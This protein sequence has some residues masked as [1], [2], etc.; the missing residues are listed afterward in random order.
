MDIDV[1]Y[2]LKIYLKCGKLKY[3]F[4]YFFY[5]LVINAN[6]TEEYVTTY[7]TI[8]SSQNIVSPVTSFGTATWYWIDSTNKYIYIISP[9]TASPW[10]T[11]RR[12]TYTSWVIWSWVTLTLSWFGTFTSQPV[13]YVLQGAKDWNFHLY[14][15]G[16]GWSASFATLTI[17]PV[18]ISGTTATL[19][20]ANTLPVVASYT[21]R[22]IFVKWAVIYV[23]YGLT[24]APYTM[25]VTRKYSAWWSTLTWAALLNSI[26]VFTDS[27]GTLAGQTRMPV[28]SSY[29]YFPYYNA[30][31]GGAR[32]NSSTDT[33]TNDS[34]I[35]WANM[36]ADASGHLFILWKII[37]SDDTSVV[38]PQALAVSW[39]LYP[40][41]IIN[42][43]L[44][45]GVS[46]G[47]HYFS[48][49]L[50]GNNRRIRHI[51]WDTPDTA[52]A[53]IYS[54]DGWSTWKSIPFTSQLIWHSYELNIIW[55]LI[56][57]CSYNT[58][59]PSFATVE[60][61]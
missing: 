11:I 60:I 35:Q 33:W 58:I 22:N 53:V 51:L 46:S 38:W 61:V 1:W 57:L 19:G 4:L 42:W 20:T 50:I 59:N 21:V 17:Y 52:F 15:T 12:H 45:N 29:Q 40:S 9:Q 8:Y 3:L 34:R 27:S 14:C 41:D 39:A 43:L 56:C 23:F 28:G 2:K 5:M 31:G 49:A 36:V 26:W 44:L 6:P 18:T 32:F 24:A 48:G 55:N 30:S 13:F 54:T 16:A 37:L 47:N 25:D 10:I 7:D